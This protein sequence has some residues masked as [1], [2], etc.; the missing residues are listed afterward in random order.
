MKTKK[1]W[2][3]G[4][5]PTPPPPGRNPYFPF[6]SSVCLP[7]T[8]MLKLFSIYKNISSCVCLPLSKIGGYLPFWKMGSCLP[9]KKKWRS[10]SMNQNSEVIFH[11]K[12]NKPYLKALVWIWSLI[13][14]YSGWSVVAEDMWKVVAEDMWWRLQRIC[15]DKG[16]WKKTWCFKI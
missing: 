10:T 5:T 1:V 7:F 15:G 12:I 4:L 8:Y 2:I 9:F 13:W 14:N 3:L 6:L 11:F 16:C